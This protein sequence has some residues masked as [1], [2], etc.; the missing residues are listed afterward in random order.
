[1]SEDVESEK[2]VAGELVIGKTDDAEKDY[3]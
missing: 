1:L 3:K 2:C